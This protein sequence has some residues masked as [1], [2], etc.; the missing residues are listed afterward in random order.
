VG[1]GVVV[2]QRRRNGSIEG[3]VLRYS[4]E[5]GRATEANTSRREGAPLP[6][7]SHRLKHSKEHQL[8]QIVQHPDLLFESNT[9]AA[10]FYFWTPATTASA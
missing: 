4:Q 8:L 7:L 6:P 1:I 2:M 9:T 5:E 10:R 3:A